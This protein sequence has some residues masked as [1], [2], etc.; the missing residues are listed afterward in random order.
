[1][2]KAAQRMTRRMTAPLRRRRDLRGWLGRPIDI[3]VARVLHR[4]L[5]MTRRRNAPVG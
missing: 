5:R 2:C 1:M 4:S 3:V